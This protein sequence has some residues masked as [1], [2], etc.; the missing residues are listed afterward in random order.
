MQIDHSGITQRRRVASALCGSETLYESVVQSGLELSLRLAGEL[1]SMSPG[2]R[3]GFGKYQHMRDL[4]DQ[5]QQWGKVE[6]LTPHEVGILRIILALHDIGRHEEEILKRL[7]ED[8]RRQRYP[9]AVIPRHSS[10]GAFVL[11]RNGILAELQ[12]DDR[13]LVLAAIRYHGEKDV[14]LEGR[15]RDFCYYLR[16][17]DKLELLSS[18]NFSQPRGV[19]KQIETHFLT[20]PERLALNSDENLRAQCL[21]IVTVALAGDDCAIPTDPIAAKTHA[22][23]YT[24]PQA[25]QE[26]IA[27]I[28]ANRQAELSN[29][30]QS[31]ASYMLLHVALIFDVHSEYAMNQISQQH[32]LDQ[33]LKFIKRRV[34]RETF[35]AIKAVVDTK[36]G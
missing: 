4:A 30:K 32:L 29:C 22:A 24:P 26:A 14:P 34:D 21:E 3:F 18:E 5:A 36:L 10:L 11:E 27:A 7:P 12:S 9:G 23:M 1:D 2:H 6:N 28:L 17:I 33:R 19:L 13:Q 31:W 25:E 16:D 8:Q 15:A 20:E 35:E